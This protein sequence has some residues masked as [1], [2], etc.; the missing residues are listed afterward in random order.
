MFRIHLRLGVASGICTIVF[1]VTAGGVAVRTTIPGT[2]VVATIDGKNAVVIKRHDL[3]PRGRAMAQGAI[4]LLVYS[5]V[6]GIVCIVSEI[7]QMTTHA[8]GISKIFTLQVAIITRQSPVR[9]H[10]REKCLHV[11]I[12]PKTH[13]PGIGAMAPLTIHTISPLVEIH[14]T[15]GTFNGCT[16]KIM[17]RFGIISQMALPT[18]ISPVCTLEGKDGFAIVIEFHRRGQG[19][20]A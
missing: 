4:R 1:H 12:V 18:R 6:S 17:H 9:T 16:I 11:P 14:M 2:Q 20:P 5:S 8:I 13:I 10:Q 15:A 7:F 3:V 19:R